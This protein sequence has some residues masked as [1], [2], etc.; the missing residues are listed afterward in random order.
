MPGN[1]C[2]KMYLNIK[3]I[4][5]KEIFTMLKLWN[6]YPGIAK[7]FHNGIKR[8]IKQ[9]TYSTAKRLW[10]DNIPERWTNPIVFQHILSLQNSLN[11]Y[12]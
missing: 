8:V 11:C 7:Y 4:F 12:L 3:K 6:I 2:K 1:L 5:Q 9:I 10:T